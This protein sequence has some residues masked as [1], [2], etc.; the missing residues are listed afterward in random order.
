MVSQVLMPQMGLEVAGGTV[1]ELAV[2]VGDR[3]V[4]GTI[5]LEVETDKALT[6]VSAPRDGVVVRIDVGAGDEVLVGATLVH[7]GDET[8]EVVPDAHRE[9]P[10]T[11]AP[12]ETAASPS[13]P[14]ERAVVTVAPVTAAAEPADPEPVP[15]SEPAAAN[16]AHP[17]RAAPVARRAAH[18]HG[19]A[20]D[21][22]AGTGP[23]GRITVG[24]VEA[25]VA[26]R[27]AARAAESA[28]PEPPSATA[29]SPKAAAAPG[30][31][32]PLSPTRR[33]IA[34]R[35]TQSAQIPQFTLH[36][37][38]AVSWLQAEKRRLTDAGPAKLSINDLLVQALAEVVT[39]HAALAA[40]YVEP[41]DDGIAHL[42][43]PE[44]VGVGLAVAGD[45][46]LLV[47]VLAR[48]HERT[49]PE[50]ALERSRLVKAARA[51]RLEREDMTG[52][53]ITLSSL[54]SFGVDRFNALLNPGETAIVAVGRTRDVLVPRDGGIAVVPMATFTM[55]LD[56]RVADG[57]TGAAALAD[58][59]DAV[60]GGM[61][62]RT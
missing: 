20:L 42:R 10:V 46:G 34:R 60:E 28:A 9:L 56:H 38:V 17:L 51:G 49:L 41:G 7:L 19:L 50:L 32:E 11:A 31:L 35:M 16:G 55:T 58:L 24:D 8:G 54:A 22:V 37:D 27:E 13:P 39:G 44:S 3:V 4:E 12:V 57:A 43:R 25:A 1:V 6:D 14:E 62:W 21:A 45:R 29:P 36:R 15:A 52:A 40:A 61:A 59:A 5:L 23:R 18:H 2:A 30:T 47:P 48:A 33:A 26:A 53:S